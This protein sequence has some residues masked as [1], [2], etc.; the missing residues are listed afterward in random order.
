MGPVVDGKY[1]IDAYMTC[2]DLCYE[3]LRKKLNG[4]RIFSVSDYNVFHTGGGFHI[5]KKS[6][7]RMCRADD[8]NS[9]HAARQQLVQD[10]LIPS[11]HLLKIIGPC[12]TVSSFL[13][14]SSVIM[15]QWDVALG[16]VLIVFTYGSGCASSMYQLR[17]DEI[18]WF[19]PLSS[20]KIEFY[21]NCIY[22][23]PS[24]YV[25]EVYVMTWMKFGFCPQGRKMNGIDP[26]LYEEDVYYLM[27]IDKW[28]RR[29]FHRGGIAAP[30]LPSEF[31]LRADKAEGRPKRDKYEV[32]K[33]ADKPVE[34]VDTLDEQWRQIEYDMT[35]DETV[36]AEEEVQQDAY[37]SHFK[38]NK[39][40][41]V[42]RTDKDHYQQGMFECDGQ[43]HKYV[44]GGSWS[45][46]A[47]WKEMEEE[48]EGQWQFTV[49]I[50]ENGY[51]EFFIVQD[52]NFDRGWIWPCNDKSWKSQ[53]CIGPYKPKDQ[54]NF[55]KWRIETR[56]LDDTPE[57][58]LGK[59]GDQFL[60]VFSWKTGSVKIVE[61][62]KLPDEHDP[63]YP[64]GKYSLQ[65]S[66]NCWD[67]VEMLVGEG[68]HHY[69]E[70]V[71]TWLGLEF[72]IMRN[73]DTKQ[74][75]MP[76]LDKDEEG[77]PLEATTSE[78]GGPID[79]PDK[80]EEETKWSI[81]GKP[82]EKY[83]IDFFR[84]PANPAEMTV[85]W[86]LS[87]QGE[88]TNPDPRYFVVRP[89]PG[90]PKSG[91]MVEMQRIGSSQTFQCD[92][93]ITS[94]FEPFKIQLF[95]RGDRT[96]HPDKKEGV[97]QQQS[98][99]VMGPDTPDDDQYWAIGKASADK[100]RVGDVF[101]IMYDI[102]GEK[103]TWKKK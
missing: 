76:Q 77:K 86:T 30:A 79:G 20:W 24:T 1:S 93:E 82:G 18:G 97:S 38:G 40:K 19:R 62:D 43:P 81:P 42:H 11:V 34:K 44:I 48:E 58:D 65:G 57:E 46:Y 72:R 69:M 47:D 83:T 26:W 100:A 80:F 75:I 25:H 29:F 98:H 50:G 6:F 102:P 87:G 91:T 99:K 28:G 9:D 14:I 74:M 103:V 60:V 101:Q 16:K 51:E 92:F 15:S 70:G 17:F 96:I 27:E 32:L 54:A 59:P 41:I 4:I 55:P 73:G 53:P 88:N 36:D 61:W 49:T 68:G 8:P 37:K 23:H 5:V 84:N 78:A 95:K 64:I 56:D 67:P 31:R 21:R 45:A 63:N 12:H 10:R 35:Y 39:M 89:G 13:N 7:E 22:Q 66:W 52:Y 71:M 2:I 85:N 33:A 94:K 90:W 3:V